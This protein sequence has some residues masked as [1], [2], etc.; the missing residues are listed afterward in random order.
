MNN[1]NPQALVYQFPCY[2]MAK[3]LRRIISVAMCYNECSSFI[4][5]AKHTME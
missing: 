5:F 4:G 2:Y 1:V 3:A